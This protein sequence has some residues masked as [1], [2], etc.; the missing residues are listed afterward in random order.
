LLGH[1]DDRSSSENVVAEQAQATQPVQEL[2]L[3]F[4]TCQPTLKDIAMNTKTLLTAAFAAISAI[5]M[6]GAGSAFANEGTYDDP[7]SSASTSTLSR[8]DVRAETVRA[9]AAGLIASGERSIV[10]VD[11]GPTLTRAQVKAESLEAIR[12]GGISRHEQSVAPTA[13]QA[14]SIRQAGLRAVAMT[15]TLSSL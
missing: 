12:V 4:L 13:A 8:A 5:S 10:I 7:V 3:W 2:L 9:R 11:T 14:E 6:L 15:M 1:D